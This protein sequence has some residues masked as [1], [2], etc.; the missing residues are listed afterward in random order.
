LGGTDTSAGY[1]AVFALVFG[2]ALASALVGLGLRDW[3]E[4]TAAVRR[5]VR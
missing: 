2:A 5:A 1:A 3:P 4:P